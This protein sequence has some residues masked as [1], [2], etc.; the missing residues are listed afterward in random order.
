V[1]V[2][3]YGCDESQGCFPARKRCVFC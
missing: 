2:T 3:L 1:A